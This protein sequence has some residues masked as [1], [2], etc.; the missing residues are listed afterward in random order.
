MY[1]SNDK[2]KVIKKSSPRD[3]FDDD[4]DPLD[5]VLN[6]KN[7]PITKEFIEGIFKKYSFN[8]KVKNLD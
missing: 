3:N 8:H 6:E 1:S 4:F 2:K 5:R 7:I